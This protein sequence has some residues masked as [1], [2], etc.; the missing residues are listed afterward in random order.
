MG[1]TAIRGVR[2]FATA[3]TESVVGKDHATSVVLPS[4][5]ALIQIYGDGDLNCCS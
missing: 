4:Q 2:R 1:P 3:E 5:A